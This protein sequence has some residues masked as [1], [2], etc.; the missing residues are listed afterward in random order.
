MRV[1]FAVSN[2]EISEAIVKRYQRDFKEIISYKNVYYFNAIIKE[3]QKDKNY[4][5]IVISE[6]LEAFTNTQ[7]S[8]IDK[9]IFDKLDS[10]SD[11]AANTEGDDIPIILICSD[12]REKGED[13]LVKLFGIGIYNALIGNDRSVSQVCQLLNRPRLK[14]DAKTYYE[15]D[16]DDVSYQAENENDVSEV[17]IQNILAHYRRLGKD[18]KKYVESFDNIASQYNDTQ[19]KII[20]KFL[21]LNVRAVLEEKS[22]KYQE[23]ISYNNRVSDNLR[24]QEAKKKANNAPSEKLLK[25]KD[26]ILSKP[27]VIPSSVNMSG[28]KK[29]ARKL[30]PHV[31]QVEQQEP[32]QPQ[33]NSVSTTQQTK[34]QYDQGQNN[35]QRKTLSQLFDDDTDEEENNNSLS[36]IDKLIKEQEE[37]SGTN[38]NTAIEPLNEMQ[39]EETKNGQDESLEETLDEQPKKRGRGRPRKTPLPDPNAPAKPKRGRGRPRKNPLPE[40]EEEVKNDLSED[41]KA[42][43]ESTIPENQDDA[44]DIAISNI[45]EA[46][47]NIQSNDQSTESSSILPGL[48][49]EEE[50]EDDILPGLTSSTTNSIS[51]SNAQNSN[52]QSLNSNS[53]ADNAYKPESTYGG[54]NNNYNHNYF[55]T[56]Q[57]TNMNKNISGM[58]TSENINNINADINKNIDGLDTNENTNTGKDIENIYTNRDINTNRSLS[59]EINY[60]DIDI[61]G[62]LTSNK[63]VA[64][65][66]GTSKNGTSF[67]VNNI[68]DITSKMGINTAILD[69]TKNRNSY[70]IYTQNEES[71]RKTAMTCIHNLLDGNANGIQ[72]G[73]NLTVYTSLPEETEGIGNAGKI[74]QTL[75]QKHSLILIDCDFKTPMQYFKKTQEIYLVQSFDILT[76]Q[77]L[78]A[79]LRELKSK[80]ILEQNKLRVVLNKALKLRGVN[81]KTI[82]GGMAFYNDPAMSFM[83]ELFDKD[84]IRY[85]TV[86][87]DEETYTYYL[88]NI[89][90][91]EVSTKRYPKHIMQI[92]N[93][94]ANMVY[95][96][97]SGRST[98]TPPTVQRNANSNNIFSASMNSTLDQ[99]KRNF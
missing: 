27:V 54:Y 3:L 29:L 36:E 83:T 75:L 61:S 71:L 26:K 15:I 69:T 10:I 86:P 2:E 38:N 58:G 78:T 8:Q 56:S 13:M 98:Y 33:Y 23:L 63:K 7:Y 24:L 6:E 22:P 39:E 31:G 80:D 25:T 65:F 18:E 12:R 91:C 45:G 48:E 43:N 49:D 99:M 96:L 11:E 64:C 59:K 5:R 21:P 19:L 28:T 52:N 4:D 53:I 41:I 1:L 68:A 94:L 76:I 57:N 79:F 30:T 66:V 92:L 95:P 74:L 62:L 72:V 81:D 89:I 40:D 90:N 88:E 42:T 84:T 35:L 20:A 50:E 14:K 60:E 73:K 9:F 70:Y 82:I 37:Q 32:V 93:D 67:M 97:V 87:F 55:M 17:E 46:K 44:E 77:P 16:T 34:Q 47:P 85:I 51:N